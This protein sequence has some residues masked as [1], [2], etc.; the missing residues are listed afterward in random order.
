MFTKLFASV[1]AVHALI[2]L[3][4]AVKGFGWAEVPQLTQPVSRPAAAVWLLAAGI[5]AAAA[6]MLFAAPPAWWIVGAVAVAISQVV[7]VTSWMDARYG[8]LVNVIVLAGVLVG[9]LH[10]GPGS[11][12]ASYA[13]DVSS[14]L[15]P[16]SS[17]GVLSEADLVSLPEIVRR[18]VRQSGA[19]GQPRV[20]NFRL[21]FRGRIRNGPTARWMSFTGEQ[22]NGY[23][24]ASRLFLMDGSLFGVP[25]QA[26]H[27]YVG[28]EASMHVKVASVRTMADVHGALMNEGET[29]TLLNDLCLFAPGAL[30]GAPIAWE[31]VDAR[32]VRVTFTNAGQ[33]VR[34][35]LFFNDA[36]ELVKF[37]S[38][39]RG[40]LSADGTSIT[41]MRWSTPSAAY[42]AF[43]THRL[44][45]GGE[46]VWDAPGGP[47]PYIQFEVVA[48]E[49]NVGSA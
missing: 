14:V 35:E 16:A 25:F 1:L 24:P 34:A 18:Y 22:V 43:G 9:Y 28:A 5:G 10:D 49:Y 12:N 46:G 30:P 38:D 17:P 41:K 4:G 36:A 8:T 6:V 48:V 7:I 26:F 20:R 44:T 13:R 21:R 19:V 27:R 45:S 31:P 33:V 15:E 23:Q 37:V 42:R 11:F 2:H 32:R 47:Y 39:D 3:L 40:A 29:V